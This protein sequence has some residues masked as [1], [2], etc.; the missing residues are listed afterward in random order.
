MCHT[1]CQFGKTLLQFLLVVCGLGSL[2]LCLDLCYT[3]R[4]SLLVAGTVDDS[5]VLFADI[6]TLSGT[7]HIEGCALKFDA[8][9]L[10][11]YRAAGQDSDVFQHLFAA[12]AEARSL[13]GAYLELCAQAVYYQ[14]S[15]CLAIN[16]FC[17]NQQRTTALH[18]GLQYGQQLLEVRDFLVVNQDVRLVHLDLHGLGVGNEIRTD[19]SAVELHTLYHVYGRVHT[20]CLADG[21]NAVFADF[22]HSVGNQLTDGR[23]VV[24]GDG[25]HLFNLVKVVA[26]HFTL[27]LDVSHNRAN[28][29]VHTAFEVH[30]VC[31][32]GNVL[33]TYTDDGLGQYRSRRG[34]VACL[35][36]GLGSHLLNQLSTKVLGCIGQLYLLGNRYTVLRD[37]RSTVFLVNDNVTPFRTERYFYCVSQLVNTFLER[38]ARLNIIG[39]ILCHNR[40]F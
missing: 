5:G 38:V 26:Y 16:I 19:I 21:D 34:A 39:Y 29:F 33:Q 9:L 2:N 3:S 35:V 12:V 22:A 11:D 17:D 27:L 7:Q 4:N 20:F 24:G 25:S 36:A 28:G 37:L 40:N 13:D 1:A 6:H 32:C 8:L 15:K 10:T 23:V 18:C 31:P 30:R 14:C